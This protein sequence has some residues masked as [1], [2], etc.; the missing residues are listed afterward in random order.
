LGRAVIF[1]AA[2]CFSGKETE[3]A[4]YMHLLVRLLFSTYP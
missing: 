2:P 4:F 3:A 1:W